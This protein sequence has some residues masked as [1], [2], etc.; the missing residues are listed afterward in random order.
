[1]WTAAGL[2]RRCVSESDVK[3][4]SIAGHGCPDWTRATQRHYRPTLPRRAVR[5]DNHYLIYTNTHECPQS[6]PTPVSTH[7]SRISP[8]NGC[9]CHQWGG[10]TAAARL[11]RQQQ[12]CALPRGFP[13]RHLLAPRMCSRE[14]T[15]FRVLW[16]P[17][18]C[19]IDP[20]VRRSGSSGGETASACHPH[21]CLRGLQPFVSPPA[22]CDRRLNHVARA[23]L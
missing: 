16:Q 4:R 13:P 20:G 12:R 23:Y 6:I 11:Q 19:R 8:S 14:T 10:C 5:Q 1:M 3:A 9:Y 22:A 7:Q 18:H 15:Y 17:P 21:G 2:A